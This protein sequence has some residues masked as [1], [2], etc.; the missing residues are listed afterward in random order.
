MPPFI[1]ENLGTILVG[2]AVLGLIAFALVRTVLNLRK[3]RPACGCGC[4]KCAL[5]GNKRRM[6]TR[7]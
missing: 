2:A 3:G 7:K 4:E 6:P 1:S 5:A